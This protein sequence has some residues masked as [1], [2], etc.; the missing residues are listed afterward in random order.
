M[1]NMT[2]KTELKRSK[3]AE[4]FASMREEII[5]YSQR[6]SNGKSKKTLCAEYYACIE[7]L[8][9][10]SKRD[11]LM[12]WHLRNSFSGMSGNFSRIAEKQYKAKKAID[13]LG[14]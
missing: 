12:I 5:K 13:K 11:L 7:V 10:L 8:K 1:R 4:T 3:T 6:N 9:T 2:A 14:A